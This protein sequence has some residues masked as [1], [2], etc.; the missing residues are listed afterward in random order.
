MAETDNPINNLAQKAFYLG[1]GLAAVAADNAAK[2]AGKAG[3]RLF[4]LRKQ[5]QTLVDELVERGAMSAEEARAFMDTIA[6]NANRKVEP[7]QSGGPRRIN[8][9]DIS[10]EEEKAGNAIELSEAARLRQQIIDLQ[11]ELDRI[12]GKS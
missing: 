8:I 2:V 6:A 5:A 11:A 9:D 7:R 10:D 3:S 12:K 1:M 4:E